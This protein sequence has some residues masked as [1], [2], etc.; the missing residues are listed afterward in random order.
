MKQTSVSK[1]R[2]YRTQHRRTNEIAQS[3]PPACQERGTGTGR[4]AQF[5]GKVDVR[6]SHS[7]FFNTLLMHFQT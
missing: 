4:D 6:R 5:A 3:S 1:V 2:A 7:P